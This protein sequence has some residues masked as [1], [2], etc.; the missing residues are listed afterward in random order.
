MK[1]AKLILLLL[2]FICAKDLS[3]QQQNLVPNAGFEEYS[4]IPLG[5]F[6]NGSQFT[7]LVKYWNSPTLASP[8][9]FGPGII[10]PKHWQK[11]G[12]GELHPFE[13]S[14]M[15]GMTVY[16]CSEGKPHC[17]EYVQIQ[18][19]DHLVVGQKYELTYW[20]G[21]LDNSL[22]IDKI[23][24][25]FTMDPIKQSDDNLIDQKPQVF[26]EHVIRPARGQWQKITNTFVPQEAYN[27][28]ILGNFFADEDNLVVRDEA[29]YEFGYYYMDSVSLRKIPPFVKQEI[30]E[31]DLTRETLEV[32]KRIQLKN[33]Y[34]D[35]DKSDLL[36][37]SFIELNKLKTILQMNPKMT[38]EVHGHTD[39]Q[40]ESDYNV[41]LSI[42]RS[43]A[44]TEYLIKSGIEP[45]RIDFKGYG[46]NMPIANNADESGRKM[47]RRV[48]ILITGL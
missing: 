47:N 14:S 36:P 35:L 46:S 3:A 25:L 13:G 42:Q 44:V 19:T 21:H 45:S 1:T 10:V 12:F 38:I 30:P 29:I 24:A 33:I 22:R 37:R 5:W 11:K 18:L 15:I 9:A 4:G 8:D 28:V 6:Y 39:T 26:T 32:G 20:L 17:R 34:F 48:E 43:K 40:G 27:Y 2:V 23:G 31:D 41:D 16:G 7:R